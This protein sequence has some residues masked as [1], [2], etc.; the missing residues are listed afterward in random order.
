MEVCETEGCWRKP[1]RV[2]NIPGVDFLCRR[3]HMKAD[4][5]AK[6]FGDL[7]AKKKNYI[8]RVCP[9]CF[10]NIE[11]PKYRMRS[12]LQFC[13]HRCRHHYYGL[14]PQAES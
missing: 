13:S 12:R 8:H 10:T 3:H 11:I 2:N 14:V 4:G 9:N 6:D 5:R 7:G 1:E